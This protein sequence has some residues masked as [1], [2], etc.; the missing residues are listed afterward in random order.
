MEVLGN[1]PAAQRASY[2]SVAEALKCRFGPHLQAE[3][4]RARLKKRTRERGETLSQLAH[5]VEGLVR[6]SYPAAQEEMIVVLARDSF[7]DAL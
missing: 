1:L 2:Q 5:D 4:Y 3:V 6:R 7:I